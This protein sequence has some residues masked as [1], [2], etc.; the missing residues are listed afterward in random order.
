[1]SETDDDD[2]DETATESSSVAKTPSSPS[3]SSRLSTLHRRRPWRA[4]IR[5]THI[6]DAHTQDSLS[7]VDSLT[8]LKPK[9]KPRRLVTSTILNTLWTHHEKNRFFTALAR[10]GKGNLAE[11]ARRVGSKSLVEVTAYVGVLD[12]EMTLRRRSL[13]GP[14][15]VFDYAMM[16]AAVEVDEQ[17]LAFEE[18]MSKGLG[19][20]SDEEVDMDEAEDDDD[21]ILNVEKAN[22]LASW[23]IHIDTFG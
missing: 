18:R 19:K 22:E 14:R 13:L 20:K 9:H 21:M 1:M 3:S 17:W 15:R 10:C 4:R 2:T 12:E 8:P 5:Y 11:V 23:Y 16:P 7:P 6:L